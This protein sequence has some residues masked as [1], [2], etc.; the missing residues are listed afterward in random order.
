[1]C[2]RLIKRSTIIIVC[3]RATAL[4]AVSCKTEQGPVTVFSIFGIPEFMTDVDSLIFRRP[5]GL[6]ELR[7]LARS[8]EREKKSECDR[9]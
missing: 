6:T 2:R 3:A 8:P 4:P 5:E 7:P 1:M 9:E